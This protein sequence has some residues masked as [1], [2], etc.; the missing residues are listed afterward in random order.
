MCLFQTGQSRAAAPKKTKWPSS[1][2]TSAE[3]PPNSPRPSGSFLSAPTA[4]CSSLLMALPRCI[5]FVFMSVF[6]T[7]PDHPWT[8]GSQHDRVEGGG[9]RLWGKT[10]WVRILVRDP[11]TTLDML[12]VPL[13]AFS[14][15][16]R[17]KEYLSP[18]VVVR[19]KSTKE[20]K[21]LPTMPGTHPELGRN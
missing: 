2:V 19:I 1:N 10:T 8:P 18:T 21:A 11:I 5:L 13:P 7:K 4:L 15:E 20:W 17:G 16:N 9:D 3:K 12:L 6:S 14:A